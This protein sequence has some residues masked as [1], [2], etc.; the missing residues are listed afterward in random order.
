[1]SVR[2]GSNLIQT[3]NVDPYVITAY[4][5]CPVVVYCKGADTVTFQDNNY[6]TRSSVSVM[7][8]GITDLGLE[9]TKIQ[10]IRGQ[11]RLDN[12]TI[13]GT[14]QIEMG[15][16]YSMKTFRTWDRGINDN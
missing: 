16:S 2:R 7:N 1:M 9:N 10:M 8:I 14:M 11:Y 5:N 13:R 15:K 3:I 12:P 6:Q 4:R